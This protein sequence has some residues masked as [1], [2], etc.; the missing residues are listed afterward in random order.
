MIFAVRNGC[1]SDY[2]SLDDIV[3]AYQ[4]QSTQVARGLLED[5]FN[6][7]LIDLFARRKGGFDY[8][9]PRSNTELIITGLGLGYPI[10]STASLIHHY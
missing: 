9:D 1:L 8:G 2:Y 4:R 6:V 5:L 7:P 10:E 3:E